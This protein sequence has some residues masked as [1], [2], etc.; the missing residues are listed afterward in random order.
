MLDPQEVENLTFQSTLPRRERLIEDHADRY[1]GP[2]SIHAPAKGATCG[3]AYL[4][5]GIYISIHAPAKERHRSHLRGCVGCYFNP[6]S[7]EGSDHPICSMSMEVAISIHA[8]AKGATRT[9]EPEPEN[10]I[11]SIHAPA[12]GATRPAARQTPSAPISIHAPAKERPV[13]L[14]QCV[15]RWHF[16]PRSREG[17]DTLT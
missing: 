12:K 9:S 15:Q 11:I 5:L 2:I 14:H 7:R 4:R 13:R 8:P 6:R 17:S 16:N 1:G 3:V 10:Q